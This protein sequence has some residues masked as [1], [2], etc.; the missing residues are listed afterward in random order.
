MNTPEQSLGNN[1]NNP[2]GDG[3]LMARASQMTPMASLTPVAL[4]RHWHFLVFIVLMTLGEIAVVVFLL[5]G[6]PADLLRREFEGL[7]RVVCVL[8]YIGIFIWQVSRGLV[9]DAT[10]TEGSTHTE[11][12]RVTPALPQTGP[13]Q[14]PSGNATRGRKPVELRT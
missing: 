9:Q 4:T 6:V 3:T 1:R 13:Q 14:N 12:M 7:G 8:A 11:T 5:R 10:Q 2:T